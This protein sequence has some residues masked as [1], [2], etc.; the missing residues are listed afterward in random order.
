MSKKIG[1]TC[2]AF[3]LLHAGHILMLEE[4]A[5][6]CD[7]LKVGLH[8][9]PSKERSYKNNPVQSLVERYIQLNATKF[10]NEIIPYETEGDL[11][12]ILTSIDI[13]VRFIGADWKDKDFTGKELNK[14]KHN[15]I[16]NT[17][18]HSFSSSN[19]RKRIYES[20]FS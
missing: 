18:D 6:K 1:F 13:D 16:Y 8:V 3:D 19:L 14:K 9:D 4:C 2:G 17:R 7:F 11:L 12:E 15:I 20:T 5:S 10:V